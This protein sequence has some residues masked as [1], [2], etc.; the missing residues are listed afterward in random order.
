MQVGTFSGVKSPGIVIS[1]ALGGTS[2]G[3]SSLTN[4]RINEVFPTFLQIDNSKEK[5]NTKVN[6][7]PVTNKKNS[8]LLATSETHLVKN[9]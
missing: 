9:L 5:L 1:S 8:D 3:N 6:D 4:E 2:R 7:L